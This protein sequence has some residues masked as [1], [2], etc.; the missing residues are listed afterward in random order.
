MAD[1]P[2][3]E[4]F[5][6]DAHLTEEEKTRKLVL[7]FAIPRTIMTNDMI[8]G[9]STEQELNTV[10]SEM[11][12]GT[13][14]ADTGE[15][16]LRSDL[17]TLDPP[18]DSLISYADFLR[19]KYPIGPE[20][21]EA[22]AA[23]NRATLAK[24]CGGFTNPSEPGQKFRPM[25]DQ[26]VKCLTFSKQLLKG[27]NINKVVMN[28]ED[29][30]EDKTQEDWANI[31]RFG[32]FQILPAFWKLLDI[33]VREKRRFS[34]VFRSF[35]KDEIPMVQ[36]ELKYYCQGQHPCYNNGNKTRKPPNMSG[37]KGSKDYRL[38]EEYIG[39]MDRMGQKLEFIQRNAEKKKQEEAGEKKDA[40]EADAA[41]EADV[42]EDL[43]EG[44]P[45]FTPTVYEFDGVDHPPFHKA[46]AG[47]SHEILEEVCTSAIQDDY[48]Y[49]VGKG[50]TAKA[51]KLLLVDD[52]E[53]KVQHIFFDGH[54]QGNDAHCVD[55]RNVVNGEQIPLEEA[56]DIYCHRVNL[57]S[58]ITDEQYFVKQVAASELKMSQRIVARKKA[59]QTLEEA[60]GPAELLA[61][62]KDKDKVPP[63]EYLYRT[64]IPALLPALEVAQR[65][66]PEDPISYIAFYMLRHQKQ[67]TK[68]IKP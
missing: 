26:M 33:L 35:G 57:W 66:R 49:W 51:G 15:W 61:L 55:V 23:E 68:T 53:T 30:P 37:E 29:L 58:A 52:A 17:P 25:Y 62:L 6:G 41:A 11:A 46:Y 42:G 38:Q 64:V 45:T 5:E 36:K 12:W 59:K 54:V 32:R 7:H 18:H 48:E 4:A 24:L 44:G 60:M 22:V 63:K 8:D 28:E 39:Q 13:I 1:G 56:K 2:L 20:V 19:D 16:D 34:I 27:Y 21:E 43:L 65:D 31:T 9:K 40:A 14:V 67:Y 10:L 47:L 50:R 3:G